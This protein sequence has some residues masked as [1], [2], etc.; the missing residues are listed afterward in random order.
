MRQA[1]PSPTTPAG[2]GR[3]TKALYYLVHGIHQH[4]HNLTVLGI[5]GLLGQHPC[6]HPGMEGFFGMNGSCS[7]HA[8]E[9]EQRRSA[10]FHVHGGLALT[11]EGATHTTQRVI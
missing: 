9:W 11:L 10:S 8:G 7:L 1:A 2:S 3:E 4:S 5:Q 6:L